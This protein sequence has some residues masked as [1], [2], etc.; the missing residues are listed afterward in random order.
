[1]IR[2]CSPRFFFLGLP[3]FTMLVGD[4]IT[5]AARVLNTDSFEAPRIE[6]QTVLG[7]LVCFPNLYQQI[8]SLQSVPGSED[9]VVG[10]EDMKVAHF[11]VELSRMANLQKEKA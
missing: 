9:I 8:P 6:A 1:M 7:S 2:W 4:F 5:A 3:G 11:G 10:K